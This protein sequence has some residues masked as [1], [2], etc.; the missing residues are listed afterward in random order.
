[1]GKVGLIVLGA[2]LLFA[3]ILG[4]CGLS[5][6]NGLVVK[7]NA[8]DSQWAQV[9][10]QM[11][12]RADLIPN[13]VNT[14]KGYAKIEQSVLTQIAESQAIMKSGSATPEQKMDAD[15][16]M[17]G[18]MRQGGFFGAGLPF[19]TMVQAYPQL[20]S[21]QQF[22]NLQNELAGTENRMSQERRLY[23]KSVEEYQNTK[24]QFPTVVVASLT[25][26]ADKPFFKADEGSKA[27]PKVEF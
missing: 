26:F 15:N 24:Q 2:V 25:G 10:N 11:Q 20:K 23:N 17:T 18:A 19:M 22:L 9:E 6:Y 27:A 3:L 1:M 12:R 13:L 4:G 5:S 8:V 16:K 14:V 7:R 21:D